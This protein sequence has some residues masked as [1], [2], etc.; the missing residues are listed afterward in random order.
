MNKTK[1]TEHF[2]IEEAQSELRSRVLEI[3]ALPDD[4][5]TPEL[6]AERDTLDKKYAEGEV[7]FRASLKALRDEADA[8]I[9]VDTE[10]LELRQLEA[11][12]SMG[13][14][15]AGVL[16]NHACEGAS[17]ELQQAH[18]LKPNQVPMSLMRTPPRRRSDQRNHAG[19]E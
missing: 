16:S 5:L 12:S 3:R 15:A 7:R 9:T 1:T 10:A 8:G 11:R 13:D 17:R 2:A 4:K 14:I 6:R 18:R 19:T